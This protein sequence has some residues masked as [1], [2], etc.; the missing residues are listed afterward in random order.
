[1]S[2]QDEFLLA[3]TADGITTVSLPPHALDESRIEV[4]RERLLAMADRVFDGEMHV[5]LGRIEYLGSIGLGLLVAL[6]RRV[7]LT[8]GRLV[9]VNV[10]ADLLGVFRLTRL[11]TILDVRPASAKES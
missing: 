8:N 5:D 6:H 1:M 10:A 11:D 2:E 9:L 3:R 7:A 4:S